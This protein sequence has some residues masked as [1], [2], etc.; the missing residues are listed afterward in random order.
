MTK[1]N[2][3]KTKTIKKRAIYVY[4]P[5][6]KMS[7]DWKNKA[8]KAGSSISKFVI[9]RVEDSL[10]KEEG[11]QGYLNRLELI[12]KLSKTEEELKNLRKENRYLTRLVDNLDAELKTHRA[13]PFL[14]QDFRGVRRYDKEL[15]NLLKEG[16]SLTDTE[17]LDRLDIRPTDTDLVLA[18][19]RQLFFL[20][21]YG[22]VEYVGR[23][24]K[25]KQ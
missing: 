10:R 17:I 2:K 20:E 12:K 4:L 22:L 3:G 8:A 7:E 21:S 11:E 25:W 9:D 16:I 6:Q 14:E 5:T 15:I 23:G 1:P 13:K 19:N 24:W 18:I